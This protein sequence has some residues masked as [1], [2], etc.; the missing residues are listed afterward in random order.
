MAED[1]FSRSFLF[2]K[3]TK[4]TYMFTEECPQGQELVKTIYVKKTAF[5]GS[6]PERIRVKLEW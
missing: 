4:N 6:R 1:Q 5:S 2:S 3:E